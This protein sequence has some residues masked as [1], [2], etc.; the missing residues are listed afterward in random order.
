MKT[1]LDDD[2]LGR[3]PAETLEAMRHRLPDLDG[4][5][6]LAADPIHDHRP[7]AAPKHKINRVLGILDQLD[8][9]NTNRRFG[10]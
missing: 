3:F 1:Q 8:R 9:E 5:D 10:V 2:L 4:I 7:Q 6:E